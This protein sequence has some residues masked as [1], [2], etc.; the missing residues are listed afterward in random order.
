MSSNKTLTEN[1]KADLPASLVVFLVA[2]PLCLGVALASGAPLLS[3]II[4]GVIGGLVVG[5]L[6]QS[7]TSVSGPAAGLAAVVLA[8]IQQLGSFDVFLS[9][10]IIA[11]F[12]QTLMGLLK[13]GFIA[14]FIPNNVIKGLLAAIGIIL[15][16]KQIPHAVGF[17]R[18]VEDD[19][20]FLQNDGE[21]TFTELLNIT[22]FFIPGAVIISM[23]S[24]AI[25]VFWHKLPLAKLRFIPASLAVVFIGVLLNEVFLSFA[26]NLSIKSS[27]LVQI[28]AVEL[29]NLSALFH[30]PGGNDFMN[31]KVWLVAIT[32]AAIASLETLL[33]IEAVDKLDPHKRQ[34][35]P[36][37]ELLAQ[38]I[39]NM[40]AGFLG[41][42]PVTSVI[43]RSSVNIQANNASK[44]STILHG[45]LLFISILFLSPILNKI[46]LAAL[47]A[48]LI[49]TGYKLAQIAIFKDMWR[50]GLPQFIPFI[51][52]IVAIV[53]TD[54]LMGVLM[55]LAVSIFYLIR[56]NFKNPFTLVKN[57]LHIG[58]VMQLT[59]P[60]QVSFFNKATIKNAL[61]VLPP[62]SKITIDARNADY[63]DDDVLE[64][65]TD[66]KNVVAPE[67]DIQLN[68]LG[69]REFYKEDDTIQF[70]P[71]IDKATQYRLQPKEVLDLLKIGNARFVEGKSTDKFHLQQVSATVDEQ[72]PMAVLVGCIDSRTSPEILF[73]AGI[74]DLLTIRIAGNIINPDI[75]GSLEIAVKKLG[76]KLIVV[77]GHSNC[78][79]V[80]LSMQHMKD[81][82]MHHVTQKIQAV[83]EQCGF[84][85]AIA[86]PSKE[87][88]KTVAIQNARNS[89]HEILNAS[90][91]IR[92]Q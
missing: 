19:F 35:P 29:N 59:L 56:S 14:D 48:I 45:V 85:E 65:I 1:L 79:A 88:L 41:G 66:F 43:V 50:K 92:T 7:Q 73:D 90:D 74:G 64:I 62:S 2:L 72:N 5:L 54:L 23:V 6:S 52:T 68:L 40:S 57:Q 31:Y 86:Q 91:Y 89:V 15:I 76:A 11:G 34:S 63:I 67:R 51:I 44:L 49:V 58:E 8:S 20:A 69:L 75:I 32:I 46:P 22:R 27:H 61:W 10:V 18:N 38:G 82:N 81:D 55:G 21:N 83:A 9:A 3:G 47:A 33:N 87:Q 24:I 42:I 84:H 12:I 80:A 28:P 4:S 25:L 60:N 17:D 30:V 53:F 36:N 26:P 78:G 13:A 71:V 70:M 37:R 16:L 39:G 77:K